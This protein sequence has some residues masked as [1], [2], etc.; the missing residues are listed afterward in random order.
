MS[1]ERSYLEHNGMPLQGAP[2]AGRVRHDRADAPWLNTFGAYSTQATEQKAPRMP[3]SAVPEIMEEP[4]TASEEDGGRAA[5]ATA[6]EP[7]AA[8]NLLQRTSTPGGV[9]AAVSGAAMTAPGVP[10]A[11]SMAQPDASSAA[12]SVPMG[13][14]AATG[15][16]KTPMPMAAREMTTAAGSDPVT[17]SGRAANLPEGAAVPG[18]TPARSGDFTPV[19]PRVLVQ[20]HIAIQTEI[21]PMSRGTEAAMQGSRASVPVVAGIT[22]APVTMAMEGGTMLDSGRVSLPV[23]SFVAPET[24]G[25]MAARFEAVRVEMGASGISGVPDAPAAQAQSERSQQMLLER[26]NQRPPQAQERSGKR[27]HIGNLQITVQRPALPAAQAPPSAPSA[28][29]QAAAAASPT[30]FNPWERLHTAFD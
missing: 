16:V 5:G 1:R 15:P 12:M 23:E 7:Q 13:S 6:S 11:R 2:N 19:A 28:Q 25:A 14:V 24:P 3:G 27:V 8:P 26:L 10:S 30:F 9:S 4:A 21:S 17:P 22:P 29:P 20:K 18:T